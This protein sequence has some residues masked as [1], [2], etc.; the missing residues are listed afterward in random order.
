[1]GGKPSSKKRTT[2]RK[3]GKSQGTGADGPTPRPQPKT[4]G[5]G[6]YTEKFIEG[7]ARDFS[8]SIEQMDHLQAALEDAACW[9]ISTQSVQSRVEQQVEV[10]DA[11][12]GVETLRRR[13]VNVLQKLPEFARD[14]LWHPRWQEGTHPPGS[15]GYGSNWGPIDYHDEKSFQHSLEMFGQRIQKSVADLQGIRHKGGRPERTDL[16]VWTAQIRNFWVE[17]LGRNFTYSTIGSVRKSEAFK[18]C[19]RAIGALDSAVT[20]QELSTAMKAVIKPM[21]TTVRV[22]TELFPGSTPESPSDAMKAF[23]DN[24]TITVTRCPPKSRG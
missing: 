24:M 5:W 7:I 22:A 10:R 16:R 3:S 8:I 15:I 9:Y 11:I 4:T 12:N 23:A 17:R 1:M 19:I 14:R 20:E 2:G 13:L 21:K 18:F 6:P